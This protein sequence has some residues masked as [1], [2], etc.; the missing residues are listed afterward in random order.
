MN[1]PEILAKYQAVLEGT[2][3]AIA[4]HTVCTSKESSRVIRDCSKELDS[5]SVE[6][7]KSLH[8]FDKQ[9]SITNDQPN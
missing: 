4:A 5:M 6:L 3:G 9:L 7:R 1:H 8:D 2:I